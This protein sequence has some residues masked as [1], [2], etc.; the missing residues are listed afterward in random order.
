MK[1]KLPGILLLGLFFLTG[2]G[3]TTE[4]WKD[5]S[6]SPEERADD[7][8]KEL[9]LEEKVS[10]M[11]DQ[12]APIERLGIKEYNWWNE[13]LHGVAR[14]GRATV[15]PQPVGMAAAFDRDMVLDVFSTIS[16]EARAKH[17]Y[18]KER[19]ER[20]RYQ[21]LT[22]WTPNINVFRDPRW[23]RGMEAY[24]EDPFMNGV[25]GTAVVK[26]LQGDR[27]GKYDKL[28]ACAKHYAVHS[29]PEWNRHS[30]NAKNIK[31]RDL[32]ETLP[33]GI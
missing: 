17:H 14:A 26:G 28:H 15:F 18:F 20:G 29:G 1:Q 21:G 16:D 10:L 22:M 8:L 9:T 23:G 7:L 27:T 25:L 2:T 11:V 5:N 19:G 33:A 12:N 32:H 4:I 31:P 6:Y 30:F 24:G 3:C 13:A